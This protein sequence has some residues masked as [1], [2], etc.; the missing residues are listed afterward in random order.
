M[1]RDFLSELLATYWF[2]PPVAL[3]RAIELRVASEERYERPMLDFGCGDGLVA[4]ALFGPGGTVD[5]G[6]DPWLA[7]LRRAHHSD[8]Y[9]HLQSAEGERLPYGSGSFATV[10][11]N[12]VLEHIPDP[13]PDLR[14][15]GRVLQEG[16]KFIFTVPSDRFRVL[17][18]G[19]ARRLDAGDPEG[20]EA[21][22][23]R[24]D[25]RLAH[26]H[27]HTPEEWRQ[28]LA[29]GGMS[30]ERSRY[31]VPASVMGL[32]DRMNVWFGIGRARSGWG[33]LA[34]PRLRRLGHQPLLRRA[35]IR[36][37]SRAW[38]PYYLMD[39]ADGE[40]GGGLLMAARK[41]AGW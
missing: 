17:L 24:V 1:S 25:A 8:A 3:W 4:R 27:Y 40:K 33:L 23:N 41:K 2:A 10:F 29:A 15:I 21:Y 35:L 5:V 12:S 13:E 20:A 19:Y 36:R 6:F 7:Q 32:W 16:G 18:D 11:S 28:L 9:R 38:R 26:Y 14:E 37:L 30:L 22:A 34:S 39:V 31:Y